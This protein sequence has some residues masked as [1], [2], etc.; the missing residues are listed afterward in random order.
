MKVGRSLFEAAAVQ[1]NAR[2]PKH[3]LG[4]RL[5]QR[6]CSTQRAWTSD[7]VGWPG[8]RDNL[9]ISQALFSPES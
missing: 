8:D 9:L 2:T 3:E 7:R 6:L 5:R 1:H 4:T